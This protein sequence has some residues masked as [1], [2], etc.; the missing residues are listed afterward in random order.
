MTKFARNQTPVTHR[1]MVC[2][3]GLIMSRPSAVAF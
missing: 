1:N 2:L 3:L